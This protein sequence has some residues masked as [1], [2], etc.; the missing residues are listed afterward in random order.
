MHSVCWD[1][2]AEVAEELSVLRQ[3]VKLMDERW[4]V[5]VA[6]FLLPLPSPLLLLLLLLSRPH[7]PSLVLLLPVLVQW[8]SSV[9]ESKGRYESARISIM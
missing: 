8:S 4:E 5:S 2:P 7:P 6:A 1:V 3:D 9:A